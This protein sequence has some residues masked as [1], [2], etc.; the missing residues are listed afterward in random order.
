MK[1]GE[2]RHILVKGM[3]TQKVLIV[4]PGIDGEDYTRYSLGRV[5]FLMNSRP[6]DTIIEASYEQETMTANEVL[7]ALLLND[8]EG[9]VQIYVPEWEGQQFAYFDIAEVRKPGL[10]HLVLGAWRCGG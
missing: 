5:T 7:D 6:V 1:N 10:V 9:D 8:T 2:L 3:L 4:N